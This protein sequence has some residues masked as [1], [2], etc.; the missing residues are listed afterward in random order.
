MRARSLAA[1]LAA[2]LALGAPVIA[3]AL[4]PP[5]YAGHAPVVSGLVPA[6]IGSPMTPPPVPALPHKQVDYCCGRI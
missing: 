4:P 1:A 2:A 5:S 6:G 3:T